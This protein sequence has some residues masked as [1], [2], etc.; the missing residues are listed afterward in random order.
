MRVLLRIVEDAGDRHLQP[1]D[2]VGDGA[3]EILR[4]HHLDHARL[5][6]RGRGAGEPCEAEDEGKG[7]DGPAPPAGRVSL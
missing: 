2:A 1:A 3:I 6:A 5:G 7:E 4:R